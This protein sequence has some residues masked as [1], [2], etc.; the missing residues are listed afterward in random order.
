MKLELGEALKRED[1]LRECIV[2][3]GNR[4]SLKIWL[5]LLAFSDKLLATDITAEEKR[6]VKTL[7]ASMQ[8]GYSQEALDAYE[9]WIAIIK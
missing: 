6:E 9:N 1:I 8:M 5:Q 7:L 3:S 4:L 2:I